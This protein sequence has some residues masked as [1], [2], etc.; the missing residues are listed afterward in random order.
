MLCPWR[1]RGSRGNLEK[2]PTSPDQIDSR[3]DPPFRE[4]VRPETAAL[5]A[6]RETPVVLLGGKAMNADEYQ[7]CR[8]ACRRAVEVV[9]RSEGWSRAERVD[10]LVDLLSWLTVGG[11]VG[12]VAAA[13]NPVAYAVTTLRNKITDDARD[14][15]KQQSHSVAS[16]LEVDS[17]GPGG[18]Q[19]DDRLLDD[20]LDA[21]KSL[22]SPQQWEYFLLAMENPARGQR[23]LTVVEIAALVGVT[24]Q[25]VIRDLGGVRRLLRR[26]ILD[27]L[28]TLDSDER[29]AIYRWLGGSNGIS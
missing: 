12:K 19:L 17:P 27:R 18:L 22:V 25:S 16:T 29:S 9:A 24:P 8:D 26:A 2:P 3:A 6:K 13:E 20:A 5:S 14:T 15:A 28:Q 1:K 11:K 10:R 23:R 4:E 21:V 7:A